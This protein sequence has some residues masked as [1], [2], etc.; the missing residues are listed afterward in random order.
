MTEWMSFGTRETFAVE[1]RLIPDPNPDTAPIGE[2]WSYGEWRLF[3]RG[4]CL[5]RNTGP[6]GKP[7]EE[8]RWYLAPL[9]KWLGTN[10]TPL[11]HEQ[12]TPAAL[13]E[14][15]NL[16]VAFEQSE[17]LLLDDERPEASIQ[18]TGMQE[19]RERHALWSGA[20][21]GVFPNVWFRR[22]SDLMEIS[23]DPGTV[24]GAPFGLEFQFN[25]G[26]VLIDAAAVAAT[27]DNFLAWGFSH[28][29]GM[30]PRP[31]KMTDS[32]L[33][34]EWLVGRTLTDVL[35]EHGLLN[36]QVT[37]DIIYPLSPEVAMFGTLTP[38][39]SEL[40]AGKLLSALESARSDTPESPILSSLVED[41]MPPNRENAWEE[42]YD[43]ALN[44]LDSLELPRSH[45]AYIDVA[46]T[47]RELGIK[48]ENMQV[49]DASL[50][51]IAIAGIGFSPT[52]LV[53]NG[54]RWNRSNAGYRFTLAH[55]LAHLLLDR[56]AARRITHAST[57]WAPVSIERRANAF[58]AMLLMP[59]KLLDAA[60]AA[61]GGME[62]VDQLKRIARRLQC[63]KMAVLE[64]AMN[65]DRVQ[66]TIFYR[67]RAEMS[68]SSGGLY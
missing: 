55:E 8:I 11:F 23:F 15:E 44:V 59:P 56:G 36:Q 14:N 58:A 5:T 1:G 22:Q 32:F 30:L 61:F 54:A 10:W 16:I 52:I 21:G 53:N 3:V 39:T 13:G 25:R 46:D 6:D 7:R 37:H 2:V 64:H 9:M 45:R 33:A 67:L 40:D 57:P 68:T 4:R 18:R 60:L 51:G 24:V 63:G 28:A 26:S 31:S 43:V 29:G 19:W 38:Q 41:R 49:G 66:P 62:T 50:R 17:R 20:A 35:C 47:L 65:L 34:T 27:L 42:G 12:R 48:V